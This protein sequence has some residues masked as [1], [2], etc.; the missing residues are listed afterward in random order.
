MSL[1]TDIIM[2]G[3]AGDRPTDNA[4]ATKG[5]IWQ[6]TDY[7]GRLYL[8]DGSSWIPMRSTWDFPASFQMTHDT[9]RVSV[10]DPLITTMDVAQPFGYYAEQS[11]AA[12]GDKFE[13]DAALNTGYFDLLVLGQTGPDCG[14]VEVRF[15][16]D[17]P[18]VTFDFYSASPTPN[19]TFSHLHEYKYPPGRTPIK[20]EVVGKNGSSSGYR[21][22]I[23]YVAVRPA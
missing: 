2:M 22:P 14:S 11:A 8:D 10:G 17:G 20:F 7:N 23:T 15:Y 12:N 16:D 1:L 18:F 5:R 4:P 19:V 13:Y 3:N 6:D 21:V 9:C